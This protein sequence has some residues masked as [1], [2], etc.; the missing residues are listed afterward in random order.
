MT[1]IFEDNQKYGL[2]DYNDNIILNAE[3]DRIEQNDDNLYIVYSKR[4]P[5]IYRTDS[6]EF[7]DL[8]Q[9]CD[10]DFKTTGERIMNWILP[11]LQLLYR[12]TDEPLDIEKTLHI[13]DILRA[14]CFIDVSP[15]A[16]KPL[17]KYRYII[18]SAHAAKLC[19][20]GEK[21]PLHTLHYNSYFKV[22]DIYEKEGV[23]QI[24][25]LHVPARAIYSPMLGSTLDISFNGLTLI[26]IVRK[27]L[28]TKLNF[29]TRDNLE[30]KYWLD[31]TRK[32]IGI[33]EGGE[34]IS[35]FPNLCSESQV[36][37]LGQ[38]IRKVADD[39]DTINILLNDGQ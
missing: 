33:D 12:D 4:H 35:L 14:G 26:E 17:H 27:S 21:Y 5:L 20:D 32:H 38:H 25:L 39:T 23:T 30:D 24:C 31:R 8:F 18:A 37:L 7:I 36:A 1:K 3:F 13:G 19:E 9:F 28:D 15:Y 22:I 34:L 2:K 16:G 10:M 11:G 6:Q 29:P